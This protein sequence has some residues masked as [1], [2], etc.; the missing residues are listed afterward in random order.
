M[1]STKKR[2]RTKHR[3]NAMGVVEARGRTGRKPTAGEKK[4]STKDEARVR[5]EDRMNKPPTWR[6]AVNRA[7]ISAVLFIALLLFVM[8]QDAAQAAAMGAFVLAFY[9]PFGY[10]FDSFIYKRRLAKKAAGG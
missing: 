7:V 2:R 5:R 6:A 8:K 4:L 9:I 10:W 1:A 3:G